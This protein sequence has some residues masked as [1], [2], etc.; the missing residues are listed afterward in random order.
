MTVRELYSKLNTMYPKELSL[1]WDNDGLMVCADQ[2]REVRR[3]LV[4]LDATLAAI[5]YAKDNGFDTLITHHPMLFRGVKSVVPENLSGARVITAIVDGIT[6]MSFHTRCDAAKG[7]VNDAL[8]RTLGFEPAE[9]FGD[10]EAPTLGRIA[11]IPEMTA[12]ELASLAKEKLGCTAVRVNGDMAKKVT[13]V[14]LCGGDG[15]DFIYPALASGADAYIT[16]DAGY[17]MAGDAAEDG[18]V[19]IEVGHFHSENPVCRAIR[20]EVAAMGIDV[21]IYN[22][23]T[24]TVV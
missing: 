13:R 6:V 23:C 2:D 4:A 19:T 22:S 1:S 15:K 5:N 12:G 14:A 24:Y 10:S 8:C 18:L 20:D 3:V 7:G 17:N 21:D 16:G 11:C 9:P